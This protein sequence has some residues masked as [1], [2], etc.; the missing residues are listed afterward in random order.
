MKKKILILPCSLLLFLLPS[1]TIDKTKNESDETDDRIQ[2]RKAENISHLFFL[3]SADSLRSITRYE[4]AV[5]LVSLP[6]CIHCRKEREYLEKYICETSTILYEVT[7]QTYQEAYDDESNQL[8]DY[9]D[10]FP[11]VN[12][13]P[14]YL[15]YKDGKFLSEHVGT[16]GTNSYDDFLSSFEKIVKPINLYMMND[17]STQIEDGENV[18]YHYLDSAENDSRIEKLDIQGIGTTRLKEFIQNNKQITILYTWRRC[19]DC[20][21]YRKNVYNPTRIR[22][23]EKKLYYYEVDGYM[24][25]KRMTDETYQELGLG[26]WSEFSKDYHLYNEDFY[27]KDSKDQKSGYTPTVVK[28]MDGA[29]KSMDVYLNE[30]EIHQNSDG[31]LSYG[32]YFHKEVGEL[33]S[34][35]KCDNDETSESY[36]KARR[37]L[38]EKAMKLDI[39]LSMSFLEENLC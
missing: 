14:T 17:F 7:Y 28:Y 26:L 11:L 38:E 6:N 20:T 36:Q 4:D 37:E 39:S 23:P 5:I 19:K 16:Y 3:N 10:E 12:K 24:L 29:Y 21:S 13:T 33:A 18:V 25:L 31:T 22:Y 34:D 30:G 27:Q 1:C 35:T 2:L 32:H 8:G 15:F 9:K